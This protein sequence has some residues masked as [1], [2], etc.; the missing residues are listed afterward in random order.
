MTGEVFYSKHW[1]EILSEESVKPVYETWESRIHPDDKFEVTM[2]LQLHLDGK[3]PGWKK[4]HRLLTGRGDWKWVLGRGRV[5]ERNSKGS[6]LRMI[7]TMTDIMESKR[8]E[9][10][11]EILIDKLQSALDEVKTLSGLLPICS[12]CK[13]IRDDQG[14]WNQIEG[15]IQRH[16]E[17]QFSHSI[18]PE[19]A[20]KMY[21]DQDWYK[22]GRD[23]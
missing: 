16:S 12:A 8:A 10:E 21:G 22:K 17:A 14:Y 1:A 5:T 19:C 11:R 4:E 13:K 15:Y 9:L 20:N 23:T 7:G 18:C 2:A 6:P 3:T